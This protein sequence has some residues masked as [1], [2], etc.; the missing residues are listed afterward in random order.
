[1]KNKNINATRHGELVEPLSPTG[2]GRGWNKLFVFLATIFLF[3]FVTTLSFAAQTDTLRVKTS[4]ICDQCK[5]TIE[6][7]LSFEKGVKK[8]SLD[9]NTKVVTVLYNPDKT[10]AG[11]IK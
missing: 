6:H 1:M 10:T 9:L 5:E 8:A 11:K 2:G 3:L 4:A 7:D